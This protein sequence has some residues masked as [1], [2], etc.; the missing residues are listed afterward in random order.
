[1]GK[2]DITN[3]PLVQ[4]VQYFANLVILNV[5]FLLCSLPVI[6]YGAAA[7]ALFTMVRKLQEGETVVAEGFFRAF[8][9]QFWQATASWIVLAVAV[10]LLSVEGNLLLQFSLEVPWYVY[11][12][13]VVPAIAVGCMLLWAVVIQPS[14]FVCTPSQ[15]LKNA[16]LLS[17]RLLPQTV[18][19]IVLYLLPL[20]LCLTAT[21]DFLRLWPL[22][23]GVFF[24]ASYSVMAWLV[25]RPM[26]LLAQSMREKG[27]QI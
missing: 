19:M 22:W 27:G 10:L 1:M 23:L 20:G 15:S 2:R 3:T 12:C 5:L 21:V 26:E 8:R 4:G 11:T 25:R 6:T 24:S 13:V 14:Y 16:L 7:S 9:S 18:G 17:L